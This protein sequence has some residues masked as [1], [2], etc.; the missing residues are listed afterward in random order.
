MSVE[1]G[2]TKSES[3]RG[4]GGS[5]ERVLGNGTWAVLSGVPCLSGLYGRV[6]SF[7]VGR[8]AGYFTHI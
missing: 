5:T 6:G 2:N 7:T 1:L 3:A 8:A 4:S